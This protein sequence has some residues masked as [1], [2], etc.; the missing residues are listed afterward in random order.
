[1]YHSAF[2]DGYA[3]RREIY[4]ILLISTVVDCGSLTD[5]AGGQVD[6]TSGTTFGQTA[7]YSC[8]IGYN[9]VENSTRTCQAIGNWSGSAPTCVGMLLKDDLTV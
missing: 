7:T 1:M 4:M 9:L 8:N 6:H 3:Y 5:P 2:G